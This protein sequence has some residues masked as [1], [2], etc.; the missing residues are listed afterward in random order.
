MIRPLPIAAE[1]RPFLPAEPASAPFMPAEGGVA[2][3]REMILAGE[4]DPAAVAAATGVAI[5]ERDAD[6]VPVVVLRPAGLAPA[7]PAVFSIHGGG[8]VAGSS[9]NSLTVNARLAAELGLVMVVPD[10]RLAPEHPYPAA[11]DDVERAW[12]W[13]EGSSEALDVDPARLVVMGGSAGGLLAATLALRL[14][15]SGGPPARALVLVQP[16]LDDRN[17]LPSTHQFT[18]EHFWDRTSNLVA[19]EAY[20]GGRSADAETTPAREPDLSGLPPTFIE[21]GQADLFRDECLELASRLSAAGVPVE[22]HVWSG[23]FHGFDGL[24]TTEVARRAVT[25]RTEFL[26]G[27]LGI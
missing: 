23:A 21:I 24:E 26:R 18:R 5:E 20:L 15:R 12:R 6:G 25:A 11:A 1:L 27:A 7:A 22:L 14:R 16:Q 13:L 19:W 3:L 17:V 10:Y 2:R 9:R 8:L 4:E